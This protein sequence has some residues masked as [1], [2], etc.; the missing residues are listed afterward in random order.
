MEQM[1]VNQLEQELTTDSKCCQMFKKITAKVSP[2]NDNKQEKNNEVHEVPN[3]TVKKSIVDEKLPPIMLT[4]PKKI[5]VIPEEPKGS[6]VPKLPKLDN[7]GLN[8]HQKRA[9]QLAK[10]HKILRCRAYIAT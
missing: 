10:V 8:G 7:N 5:D 6:A 4:P 9:P 2:A 3:G 1:S